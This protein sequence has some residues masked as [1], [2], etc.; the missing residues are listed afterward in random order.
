M[1]DLRALQ[2]ALKNKV[3]LGD[4]L[5][6]VRDARAKGLTAPV[7]LMGYLNPFLAYGLD[8]LMKDAQEAGERRSF[9]LLAFDSAG[10][11]DLETRSLSFHLMVRLRQEEMRVFRARLVL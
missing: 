4:C 8:K 10:D 9:S 1:C 3:T 11:L 7:V 6:Y 2:I 5:N